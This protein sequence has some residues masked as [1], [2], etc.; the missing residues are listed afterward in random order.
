MT[1][2]NARPTAL[3]VDRRDRHECSSYAQE[4]APMRRI[5]LTGYYGECNTG[6]DA[7]LAVVLGSLGSSLPDLEVRVYPTP[8]SALPPRIPRLVT[9]RGRLDTIRLALTADA[10]VI[11]G[12]GVTQHYAPDRPTGL[13]RYCQLVRCA[14]LLGRPVI[15][16]GISIGPLATLESRQMA[17]YLL[18]HSVLVIVR[19]RSSAR[20]AAELDAA[21]RCVVTQDLGLLL[22][23]AGLPSMVGPA[24]SRS[25]SP[26]PVLGVSVM[27]FYR[28]AYGDATRDEALLGSIAEA[29]RR[30][31]A[32]HPE[33]SVRLICLQ[34]RRSRQAEPED[35]SAARYVL[36]R[37]TPR[38]NNRERIELVPYN[39]NPLA[40]YEEIAA[41]DYLVGF[42]LHSSVFAYRAQIPW[43]MIDFHPKTAGF[44][45]MIGLSEGARLR[46]EEL[47]PQGLYQRLQNLLEGT[48]PS[49]TV[50]LEEALADSRGTLE[51]LCAAL[52]C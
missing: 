7:L 32:D 37:I 42:R 17:R 39:P 23:E 41:C 50:P 10:I 35:E 25:S 51:H 28:L 40:T 16:L 15:W 18:Q 26:G 34:G 19:D 24:A 2:K 43:I 49:P 11:G 21:D 5:F 20:L 38:G 8:N 27:P 31:L 3:R 30:L 6:D 47:T 14:R 4:T 22:P 33:L 52:S 36:E 44:A 9:R 1:G 48:I 45:E 46:I 29:L 12:G 13:R